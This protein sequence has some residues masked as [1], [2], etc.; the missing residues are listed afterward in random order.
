MK[1]LFRQKTRMILTILAITWGTFTITIMLAIGEGLRLNFARTMANAGN[2]LLTITPGVTAK[3]YQ[4][5]P[6]N[7]Q[8]K[9]T[10]RDIDTIA[11]LP[12]IAN[13]TP[14]NSFQA[15][16][17]YYDRFTYTNFQA[18]IP[19]YAFVHK[20][21]VHP[22]QRF[23][24]TVDIKE[25]KSVV[26]IGSEIATRLFPPT[27][28]PVG[29]TVYIAERPFVIIGVMQ[30]KA[31]MMGGKMPD[32]YYNFIP[33]STYKLFNNPQKIET[34]EISYKDLN[35]LPE[36][37]TL[38]QKIIALNHG[39]NP[40]DSTFI[41]FSEIAKKQE[42]VNRFF[43]GM[44]L[45]LGI[46]G[47]LTLLIAGVGI[48]NVMYASVAQATHQIGIQMALGAT[49]KRIVSQYIFES[50]VV[51]GIG[52]TIGMIMTVLFVFL[53][54]LIPMQGDFFRHIGKPEPVLSFLVLAI[55]ITALGV[56]GFFAG[57]FPAL[58]AAKIDPA[59]AL[60]YE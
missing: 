55:V 44:Q 28:N 52:G 15:P 18:V 33:A 4:G 8:I 51:T 58:K 29:D 45:A 57:L 21:Q 42:E 19:E 25:R 16:L 59:E 39:Y 47:S 43:T 34:I 49:K 48:A 32:G 7:T 12:N 17:R 10:Q 37:Q 9:F 26:V 5:I 24:S 1:E 31:Q 6:A 41:N 46:I 60:V 36:T 3:N 54:R 35:L 2:K 14:Q 53:L 30:K 13:V 22:N 11:K 20:I 40:N 56:T 23:I 27:A 50:L 38:I